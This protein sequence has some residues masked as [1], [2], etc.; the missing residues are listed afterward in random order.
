M[1]RNDGTIPPST[2]RPGGVKFPEW[3]RNGKGLQGKI[4]KEPIGEKDVLG[5]K[6]EG[7]GNEQTN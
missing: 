2:R 4:G 6:S 5:A 1:C 7:S 3:N